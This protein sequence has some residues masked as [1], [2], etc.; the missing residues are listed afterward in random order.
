MPE[1]VAGAYNFL[2]ELSLSTATSSPLLPLVR[3]RLWPSRSAAL[4]P[5]SALW[6]QA[7][8]VGEVEVASTFVECM[9]RLL[10][11]LPILATSTTPAGVGLLFRRLTGV[12]ECRPF[13]LDLPFSVRRFFDVT[14]PRLLVLVETELWPGVLSEAGR[15]KTPVLLVNGRLSERSA[16]RYRFAPRFFRA[17]LDALTRV[18]ARSQMDAE[19]FVSIGVPADRVTVGGDMKLD[20][21]VPAEPSFSEAFRRLAASRPV[22]VAGSIADR[23]I[24]LALEVKRRLAADGIDIFLLLAP[25]RPDSFDEVA[26]R[27][28]EEG[29]RIVRRSRLDASGERADVFLLDSLGELAGAYRLGDIALLGGTF[30]PKGGHNV[31]EPL[32]AGL[33]VL[34]GPSIWNIREVLEA[35]RG[36]VFEVA[37]AKAAARAASA[38]LRDPVAHATARTAAARVFDINERATA[39]AAERVLSLLEGIR[40]A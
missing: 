14:R 1:P 9:K 16:R 25:R 22:L 36:A 10:P 23:E 33:P 15:R 18:S 39:R 3:E 2:S 6:I 27:C 30:A 31:L 35:A 29:L 28:S 7:V 26:R 4:R 20:R 19:R 24:P 21:P 8:S 12:A 17:P 5:E 37:D 11:S 40:G 13:P 38:L 32:R 34:H